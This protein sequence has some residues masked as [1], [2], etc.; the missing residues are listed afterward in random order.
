MQFVFLMDPIHTINQDKDSTFALM[1][2]A[3]RRGHTL[4]YGHPG[5]LWVEHDRPRGPL[6]PTKVRRGSPHFECSGV[7]RVYLDEADAVFMRKDPPFDMS[8]IFSTYLL[9]LLV[10]KTLVINDP[11]GIKRA[12]EKLYPLNFPQLHPRTLISRDIP[13]L[14]AFLDEQGGQMIVKPWDGNGGRGVLFCQKQDRNL[15][16]LLE[17]ATADGRN[18][19]IAQQYVPEVRLGDKRIILVNG[20]PKG[21]ILRVPS[22]TEHRGNIHVG[23]RVER[24]KLTERDLEICATIGPSLRRDGLLF[25]GIDVLG[26]YLTE[27]N[28]TSPTGIQ[29]LNAFE[30]TCVEGDILDHVEQ[31][32]RSGTRRLAS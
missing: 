25:V 24:T 9:D 15:S 28:V 7:E 19:V 29:E 8:Y 14:R 13:T 27:I 22:E 26:S 20:E 4:L 3:Q 6:Y 23:A 32:V 16:S 21:A 17:I 30:G 31:C 10:G 11:I 2:E 12:N 5:E 18:Y 1:L